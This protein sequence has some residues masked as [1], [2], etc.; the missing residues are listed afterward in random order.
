MV[1]NSLTL[2]GEAI[3]C[4]QIAQSGIVESNSLGHQQWPLSV[5]REYFSTIGVKCERKGCVFYNEVP[6]KP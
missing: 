3:W 4:L 1:I 5:N 6:I 2:N